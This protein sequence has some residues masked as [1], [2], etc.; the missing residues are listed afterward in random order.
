MAEPKLTR[1]Q[2]IFV[3]EYL[4]D[5]NGK[6]AAIAA[7]YSP[8]CAESRA[9]KLLSKPAIAKLVEEK[10][11]RVVARVEDRTEHALAKLEITAEKVLRDIAET[12][13]RC[14]QAHPVLDKKGNPVLVETENGSLAAAY[15]FEPL[16]VLKGC[17]LLGKHLKLFVERVERK[18]VED[19][20]AKMT[21]AQIDAKLKEAVGSGA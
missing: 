10:T 7:G 9:S 11:E 13:A 4:S 18:N 21:E 19:E 14:K 1:Q 3:A 20:F 12:V 17:E 16:A 8:K 2:Q 5:S 15:R 6:R